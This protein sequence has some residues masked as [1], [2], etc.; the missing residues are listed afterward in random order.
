[1]SH[2]A[3]QEIYFG[4]TFKLDEILSGIE[5]TA[6]VPRGGRAVR[7]R[8]AVSVSALKA[9]TALKGVSQLRV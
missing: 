6:N 9:A 2:L 8:V 5:A 4:R 1:M 3:R 7:G